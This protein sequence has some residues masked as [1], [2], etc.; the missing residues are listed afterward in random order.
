METANVTGAAPWTFSGR[1]CVAH[2]RVVRR[3]QVNPD[4]KDGKFFR[5]KKELQD[6]QLNELQASGPAAHVGTRKGVTQAATG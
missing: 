1:H 4:L 6:E 2:S 5:R 3:T